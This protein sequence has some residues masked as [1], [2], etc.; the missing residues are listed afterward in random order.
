MGAMWKNFTKEQLIK[1]AQEST[2]FNNFGVKIGYKSPSKATKEAIYKEYPEIQ[3]IFEIKRQEM[4]LVGKR[5]ERLLVL[6]EARDI[7]ELK[8]DGKRWWKCLCDC[9]NIHYTHSANL[10]HGRC[11]SCGCLQK[12]I[13]AS[14]TFIDLTG[15][16]FGRL[17]VIEQGERPENVNNT[18]AYWWCKCSCGN[19][20]LIL[21]Q[22]QLLRNGHKVSCGCVVSQ[23]EEKAIKILSNNQIKY[24]TQYTFE[25]LISDSGKLLRFDFAIF[26]DKNELSHLIE[27][28]GQQ[29]FKIVPSWGGEEKYAL[30]QKYDQ[31]K[32]DYCLKNNIKLIEI[33][34]KEEISLK[35]L[36]IE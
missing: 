27:I 1:M 7:E 32:R 8:K 36:G 22:G 30:R 21:A 26:N 17:T 16:T 5:F 2:S 33:S 28:Q 15:Q 4:E 31:M 23:Y 25:D 18:R 20:E 13:A 12:E 24:K 11:R 14:Q 19:P 9:G 35:T 10:R 3:E 6:E 29:H 34:Y